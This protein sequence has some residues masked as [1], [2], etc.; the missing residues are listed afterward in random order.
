MR[1]AAWRGFALLPAVLVL[2][3]CSP[4]HAAPASGKAA[5][6]AAPV[7]A[8]AALRRE[9]PLQVAAI[10]WSDPFA[11]V[12]IR[13][14]VEGQLQ[15]IHFEEGQDVR[16][17]DLLFTIDPRSFEAALAA[18]EATLARDQAMARDAR[19]EYERIADLFQKQSA[20][21]RE[22]DEAL[23]NT[24]AMEAQVE[25]DR[26]AC[27]T[28]RLR[29][30][31][32]TIRSPI[33]A[34]AGSYRAHV[35]NIVKANETEL[36]VLNTL[37]PICVSFA[38]AERYLAQVKERMAQGVLDVE[39][40]PP[41]GTGPAR[42]V[43][44]FIDNEVDRASGMIRLKATFANQ[45]RRL[46]PGQF[47]NVALTVSRWPDALL[48]PSSAV[49]VSQSGPFVFVVRS[50]RTVEQRPVE[51]GLTLDQEAV[52]TSGLEAGEVVVTE[53]QLRLVPGAA[54]DLLSGGPAVAEPAVAGST[55]P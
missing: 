39:A 26:A 45:D 37:Q 54:V 4:D 16:V 50:D 27:E 13:P 48:I 8:A 43:L 38:V 31:Y 52:V 32:C 33:D 51:L 10:G 18:A 2:P 12:V 22:R 1:S 36:V 49:Q 53:G 55:P 6:T 15:A 20:A 24:E 14:Q 46:W 29:L 5:S 25:A 23:A 42:G 47:L 35:G 40:T 7:H 41:D 30:G 34:R 17:G 28:A 19:R 9:V 3:G 21:D 44:S 11:S